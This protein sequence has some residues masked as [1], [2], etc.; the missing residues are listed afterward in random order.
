VQGYK[1]NVLISEPNPLCELKVKL[2]PPYKQLIFNGVQFARYRKT[3]ETQRS[4]SFSSFL[5]YVP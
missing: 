3:I 5:S 2:F 1:V 4:I